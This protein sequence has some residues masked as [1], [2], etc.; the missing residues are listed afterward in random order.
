MIIKYSAEEFNVL[1]DSQVGH[2]KDD[3]LVATVEK[4]NWD[5]T[6]LVKELAKKLG[7]SHKGV[8]YAGLKDK[9]SRSIQKMSFYGVERDR[10]EELRLNDVSIIDIGRGDRINIGDLNGNGF[11]IVVRGLKGDINA[12]SRELSLRIDELN[13]W[14]GF[15][16]YFGYQR[17][18]LQRPVT[19]DVG[20][21]LVKKDYEGAAL[22]YIGKV[23]PDDPMGAAR[24][25]FLD[26]MDFKR[27]YENFPVGLRYE[28]AMLFSLAHEGS[29]FKGCFKALPER[30]LNL[31]V[32]GYQSK[33][34]NEIVRRRT[35]KIPPNVAEMGDNI[36]SERFG[37]KA[38]A[39]VNK[40]NI[41]RVEKMVEKA[42]VT[43]PMPT[44]TR[45]NVITLP[46]GPDVLSFMPRVDTTIIV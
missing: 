4:V 12:I 6:I 27:A 31:F 9:R 44:I 2:K 20:K 30:L 24:Q 41:T 11:K 8:G 19:A 3:C 39:L 42:K 23:Y 33:L 40:A 5:T 7:I 25:E 32:H 35:E 13:G 18:G 43:A 26:D 36:V 22:A 10:L 34:F 21:L 17:F 14:H 16:N 15:I 46:A 28:R 1:E 45:T 37:R 29:D 38:T